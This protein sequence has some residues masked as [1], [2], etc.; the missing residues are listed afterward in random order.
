MVADATQT[1][2]QTDRQTDGQMG[3]DREAKHYRQLSRWLNVQPKLLQNRVSRF[4][5]SST[6]MHAKSSQKVIKTSTIF[7]RNKPEMQAD[8][9]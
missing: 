6:K 3:S 8:F 9:S 4:Q 2:E 5:L 7:V 1:D